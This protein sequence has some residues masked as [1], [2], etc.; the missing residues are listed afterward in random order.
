MSRILG[1]NCQ[2]TLSLEVMGCWEASWNKQPSRRCP[3]PRSDTDKIVSVSPVNID[4][5]AA[6]A[7]T[8]QTEY[9]GWSFQL[10]MAF[11]NYILS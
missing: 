4:R 7:L 9:H 1:P 10:F 11:C 6:A 2:V 3:E 5:G 8:V